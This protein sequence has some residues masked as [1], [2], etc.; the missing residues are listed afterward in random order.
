MIYSILAI[1]H[2]I[3]ATAVTGH[4]LLHKEDV[5]AAT[6]WIG[7]A[8][9]SPIVGP[10]AYFAL[11]INRVARRA[12]RIVRSAGASAQFPASPDFSTEKLPDDIRT[13][14][15]VGTRLT[16]LPLTG[17]NRIE[18][19]H[20]GDEA[21]PAMLEAI[22][23]AKSTIA[24]SSYIFRPDSVGAQFVDAL[25]AA[26]ARGVD[27]RVL[28]DGIGS[29][30]FYS[31][32]VRALLAT[33][34]EAARFAHDWRP[35]RMSFINLRN[36]KKLMVIDGVRGFAG[37]LN[38]G[39]ENILKRQKGRGTDDLHFRLDGPIV[40]QLTTS[41]AEDWHF[42]TGEALDGPKWWPDIEPAGN[43]VARAVSSGPDED[44]GTIEMIL[45]TAISQ[46]R[47]KIRIVT[48]YFLPDE[49]LRSALSLAA[50]RG[51]EVEIVLPER[52]DHVWMDWAMT[53]HL[54]HF[55]LD[56]IK[57]HLTSGPF[58]HSKLVTVDGQWCAFGSPNWDVRS[59]R[60]NFELLLE[61]YGENMTKTVNG[62]IDDKI[63]GAR[64][65]TRDELDARSLPVRLRD[66]SFRML[67]PYL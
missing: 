20:A 52:S 46:A 56:R 39:V 31:P 42:T 60:L 7:L 2:A 16:A 44:V 30:Y 64:Q 51:V 28:V 67:L 53:A 21:Y 23:K 57:C 33:G 43:V 59:L 13:T 29:G 14:A 49:T 22:G 50:L 58:D 5:R 34:I 63:A 27:I 12:S 65:Y 11:G 24:L 15:V 40:G 6:A 41:F 25:K 17:G 36:H 10:T 18:V 38:L 45:A 8:W 35:W 1:V 26:Q 9:L 61:C 37:G 55:P 4:V 62:I 19:L 54:E 32:V 66:A 47:E 3:A 48:P